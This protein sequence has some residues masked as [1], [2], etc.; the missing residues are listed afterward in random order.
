MSVAEHIAVNTVMPDPAYADHWGAIVVPADRKDRL[1]HHALLAWAVRGRIP[2]ETSAVHGLAVLLGPPG[3]GKTTL[4]RGLAYTASQVLQGGATRLIEVHPHGMMSAE[5][6]QT[7]QAVSELLLE[8]VPDLCADGTPTIVLLDE[9][10]SMAVARSAAS[11]AANP[12][13]V[14]RATDAVLTALDQ[15][16]RKAPNIFFVVTSN[17]PEGLDEA[18]VSRADVVLEI[19]LPDAG[20]LQAILGD[21]LRAWGDAYPPLTRLADDESLVTTARALQGVDGRQAR[22]LVPQAIASRLETALDPG[23]LTAADLLRS[24]KSG[25]ERLRHAG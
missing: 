4:A 24:A 7:Q 23:R 6:G 2:F 9:V 20:A 25:K 18:F 1:L 12:V 10:E 15:V 13:D 8:H 3:T 21:T 17:Y 5:H 14:H 16:T 19:G 11:L 22:K